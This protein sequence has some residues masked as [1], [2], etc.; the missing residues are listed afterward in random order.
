MGS[1]CSCVVTSRQQQIASKVPPSHERKRLFSTRCAMYRPSSDSMHASSASDLSAPKPSYVNFLTSGTRSNTSLSSGDK[2][3]S[4]STQDIS[5]V[6]SSQFGVGGVYEDAFSAEAS[7]VAAVTSDV[8]SL[9]ESRDRFE[10]PSHASATVNAETDVVPLPSFCAPSRVHSTRQSRALD[11]SVGSHI[12]VTF[13]EGA[14]VASSD[15]AALAALQQPSTSH[16]P[17]V[18]S[19]EEED[20]SWSN[21]TS[22]RSW[23]GQCVSPSLL[24]AH[25]MT[26]LAQRDAVVQLPLISAR[27]PHRLQQARQIPVH[28]RLNVQHR[29][30][31]ATQS[32]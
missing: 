30:P 8:V 29:G 14:I 6:S 20:G 13:Y 18:L 4:L 11:D 15:D 19:T 5:L 21:G 12:A 7:T 26:P 17:Q 16:H 28:L 31:D 24:S 10:N 25:P 32:M 1:T 22:F 9:S 2:R 27:T 3:H 23:S